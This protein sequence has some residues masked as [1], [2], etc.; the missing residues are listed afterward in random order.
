[1]HHHTADSHKDG[2]GKGDGAAAHQYFLCFLCV[3]G[4]CLVRVRLGLSLDLVLSK[5][6]HAEVC[7]L[8][9]PMSKTLFSPYVQHSNIF[10]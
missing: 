2:D 10:R 3:S 9:T 5:L 8:H 1:M 7:T 6:V 4:Y